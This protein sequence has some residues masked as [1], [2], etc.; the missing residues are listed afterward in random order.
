MSVCDRRGGHWP[1]EMGCLAVFAA[2]IHTVHAAFVLGILDTM[3]ENGLP[4]VTFGHLRNDS[5]DPT[6]HS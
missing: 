6:A 2:Y 1:P 3:K 4:Q 5:C